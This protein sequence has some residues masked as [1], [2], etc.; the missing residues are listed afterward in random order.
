MKIFN[1]GI[2]K[3]IDNLGRVV[4]PMSYRKKLGLDKN[5]RV[6]LYIAKD[7]IFIT[8]SDDVCVICRK[9]SICNNELKI[10][11]ECIDKI[12]EF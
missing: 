11:S 5:P 12:K 9:R 10:C 3:E 4:L 6:N 7:G 8:S 1:E 2:E